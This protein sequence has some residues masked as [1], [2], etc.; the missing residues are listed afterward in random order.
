[1]KFVLVEAVVLA[2]AMLVVAAVVFRSKGARGMLH[3]LRDAALLYV[4]LIFLLGIVTY[5]RRVL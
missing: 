2:F 3:K 4:I 1:M 5:W